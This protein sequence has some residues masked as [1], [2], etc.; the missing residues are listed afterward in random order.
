MATPTA[1]PATVTL[2]RHAYRH[3]P[4]PRRLRQPRLPTAIPTFVLLMVFSAR[5]LC[6]MRL[7][8]HSLLCYGVSWAPLLRG[9]HEDSLNATKIIT[10]APVANGLEVMAV[11]ITLTCEYYPEEEAQSSHRLPQ[12][13]TLF[14][15]EFMIFQI[16]VLGLMCII[17]AFPSPLTAVTHAYV[18]ADTHGATHTGQ[19]T[20]TFTAHTHI[21]ALPPHANGHA[22]PPHT[23]QPRLLRSTATLRQS[24]CYC[25]LPRRLQRHRSTA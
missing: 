21:T 6:D 7:T 18:I 5:S 8:V 10:L 19:S 24:H 3:T 23:A 2:H 17:T 9:G 13:A 16:V 15:D 1:T 25:F 20:A 14:T 22:L 12:M 4:P 11:S